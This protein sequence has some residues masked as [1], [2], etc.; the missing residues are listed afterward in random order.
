VLSYGEVVVRG[1]GGVGV[2][3]VFGERGFTPIVSD[4]GAVVVPGAPV[5]FVVVEFVVVPVADGEPLELV[6]VLPVLC[7]EAALVNIKHMIGKKNVFITPPAAR[8]ARSVI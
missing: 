7:A 2:G 8:A 4:V 1:S 5:A 6:P 3:V